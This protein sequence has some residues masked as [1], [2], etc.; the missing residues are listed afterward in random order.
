MKGIVSFTLGPLQT[1]C[2]LV[3]N[4]DRA[5]VLDP[6]GEP[7]GVL[8][9]LKD[10]SLTLTHILNTHLHCDHIYG[11][12]ALARATGAPI[13]ASPADRFLL[14]TP[15]GRGGEMIG[16]PEVQDFEFQ[17]L[18][19]GENEFLGLACR[20]LA[21]PGHSPGSL[22]FYFP[23]LC[24]ALVGD[25]IFRRSVGR[26]DFPGG[27]MDALRRSVREKI[28]SLPPETVLYTGH[29]PKTTVDEER[30][31]NPFVSGQDL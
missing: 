28:F 27:D 20:V 13:L 22:S 15:I 26:T 31:H 30:L 16:L 10:N 14:E 21:T 25:L 9:F 24:A 18:A 4:Q 8:A 11:N 12:R 23:Q 19:E 29:G 6:G 3:R 5:L 17:D 7:S 1:N 2:H